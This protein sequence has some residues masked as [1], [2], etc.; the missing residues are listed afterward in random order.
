MRPRLAQVLSGFA[1]LIIV[2]TAGD[3]YAQKKSR[4]DAEQIAK[5]ALAR[6]QAKDYATAAR[7]FLEAFELSNDPG[8]L[9]NAAKA[10]QTASMFED[11][12]NAW[13]AFL[14]LSKIT[15]KERVEATL[16]LEAIRA[17]LKPKPD[18]KVETATVAVSTP[19]PNP[20]IKATPEPQPS[21][22]SNA[23]W[24]IG[25]GGLVA[26]GSGALWLFAQNQLQDLEDSLVPTIWRVDLLRSAE[27]KPKTSS[28]KSTGNDNSVLACSSG[29]QP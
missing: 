11:A 26:V 7:L 15:E 13:E 19:K 14:G 22:S 6:F 18:P 28:I 5:V 16:F 29:R 23:W 9:W 24:L 4:G 8:P 10:F 25:G 17:K 20:A 3:L 21:T 2:S 1:A 12:Q 27:T